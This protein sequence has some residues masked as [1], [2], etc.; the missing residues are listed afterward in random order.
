MSATGVRMFAAVSLMVLAS[1]CGRD[2]PL[3]DLL[4]EPPT[5]HERYGTALREV[6]LDSTALG[7]DWLV[8]ADS[9]LGQP[10]DASLPM[11]EI[12]IY[13]REAVHAMAHRIAVRDGQRLQVVVRSEG[14][15]ARIFVDLFEVTEN[16]EEPYRHVAHAEADSLSSL[17]TLTHEA[18]RTGDLVIR[19]QPELLRDGRYAVTLRTEPVLAFPV[20]GQGNRAIQSRFGVDRDGGARQHDGIDIF[21]ARGTPVI[22]V[23]EGVV[24]STRP[25][26]LGGKVVWLRD[27]M[28]EQSMYYAHLDSQTVREGQR[29]RVGDTIGF[30][31]NTGNAATTPPHLHFGI[32]RRP[33]GAIDPFHWVALTD[34]SPSPIVVDTAQLGARVVPRQRR[35]LAHVGPDPHSDT[36][37]SVSAPGQ[38][39]ITGAVR[40]WYRVRSDDG[41]SGYLRAGSVSAPPR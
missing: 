6:G 4:R 35:V 25:N 36:V 15:P 20:T 5:P 16:L 8:A 33:G 9:V 3:R 40:S 38:M 23:A 37:W 19:I 12:G 7:R 28:R 14:L 27:P 17:R 24:R 13:T 32:Y 26:R 22:A 31:G 34:T 2:G 39:Q 11:E 18:R 29:V 30:V 41:R 1:G 10:L 21:S